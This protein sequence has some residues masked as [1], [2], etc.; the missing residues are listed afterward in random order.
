MVLVQAPA[1]GAQAIR[2]DFG[3]SETP[4]LLG[5]SFGNDGS[6]RISIDGGFDSTVSADLE[7]G[8]D[9]KLAL[10]GIED[11]SPTAGEG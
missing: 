10:L 4:R 11:N 5:A 6:V 7:L 2:P 9:G 8:S 1:A 3:T